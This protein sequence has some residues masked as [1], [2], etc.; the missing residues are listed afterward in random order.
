MNDLLPYSKEATELQ[1]G[2][3]EHYKGNRYRVLA[4]ARHSESLEELVVYQALQG[5]QDVWV[6]P[7][8]LFL[9][10]ISIDGA[11]PAPRFR[12]ISA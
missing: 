8:F 2:I 9:E 6:R 5:A 10:T 12:W 4:V 7:L 3:Y 1:L 11:E